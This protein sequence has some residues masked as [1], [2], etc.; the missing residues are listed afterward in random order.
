MG[1]ACLSQPLKN[2]VFIDFKSLSISRDKQTVLICKLILAN[3]LA[4]RI[5]NNYEK[6]ASKRGDETS[7]N[8][9]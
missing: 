2:K 1:H 7:I 5:K 6:N 4:K 3:I 8:F 9:F